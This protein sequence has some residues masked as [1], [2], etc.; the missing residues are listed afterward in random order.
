[1][2]HPLVFKTQVSQPIPIAVY[3]MLGEHYEFVGLMLGLLLRGLLD[4]GEY[5][6][7]GVDTRQYDPRDPLK[8]LEGVCAENGLRACVNTAPSSV[9]PLRL[10][11]KQ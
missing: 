2:N 9:Q 6:V 7:V 1:M 11:W 4:T 5:F 10:R 8:Y 3:V